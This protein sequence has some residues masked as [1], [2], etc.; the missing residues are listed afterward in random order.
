MYFFRQRAGLLHFIPLLVRKHRTVK[1]KLP[2]KIVKYLDVFSWISS[3]SNDKTEFAAIIE[4]FKDSVIDRA[5]IDSVDPI[6]GLNVKCMHNNNKLSLQIPETAS[7][8]KDIAYFL[9]CTKSIVKQHDVIIL[10]EPEINLHP[11]NQI[12]LAKIIASLVHAGL[13]MVVF[14]HSPYFLEQLS[15][16]VVGGK[17]K[18]IHWSI[19]A[20]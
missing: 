5:V 15:H 17:I 2:T 3:I 19:M 16:C 12:L 14:T 6:T 1:N 7:Y 4:D 10:E 20:N 13:Y 11:N 18:N 9:V 8:I